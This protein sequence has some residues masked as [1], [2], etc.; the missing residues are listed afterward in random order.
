MA[1]AFQLQQM[2]P[3]AENWI[4]Y[5]LSPMPTPHYIIMDEYT[6]SQSQSATYLGVQRL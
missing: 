1:N 3:S 5:K 2:H 6:I 4:S